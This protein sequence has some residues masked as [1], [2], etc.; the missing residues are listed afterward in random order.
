M[1]LINILPYLSPN[2]CPVKGAALNNPSQQN[3]D[4]AVP[5]KDTAHI[6]N[7]TNSVTRNVKAEKSTNDGA[8][9]TSNQ[10]KDLLVNKIEHTQNTDQD[11]QK[12]KLNTTAVSKSQNK[13]DSAQE[14]PEG[15]DKGGNGAKA[16]KPQDPETGH[17]SSNAQP[18]SKPSDTDNASDDKSKGADDPAQ[19]SQHGGASNGKAEDTDSDS[20][21]H[22]SAGNQGTAAVIASTGEKSDTVET[23]EENENKSNEKNASGKEK[24]KAGGDSEKVNGNPQTVDKHGGKEKNAGDE[25]KGSDK[26]GTHPLEEESKG[27]IG[28]ANG[29]SWT[30]RAGASGKEE[31]S[32]FFAYLVSAAVFVAVLYVAYHNKRKVHIFCSRL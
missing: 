2:Y 1:T 7:T 32:H 16:R 9:S 24:E 8:N 12:P 26:A 5:G 21:S 28:S 29:K 19:N 6:Q 20:T 14:K 13:T 17:G 31:S 4:P 15:T 25:E 27:K 18:E 23:H 11:P 30:Y 3:Q 10:N 22:K